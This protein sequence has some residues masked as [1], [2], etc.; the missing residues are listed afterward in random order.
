MRQFKWPQ[1]RSDSLKNSVN[2]M[3]NIEMQKAIQAILEH[4]KGFVVNFIDVDGTLC[5]SIFH[6]LKKLPHGQQN[7]S[8]LSPEFVQQLRDVEP[9]PWT[10]YNNRY[11]WIGNVNIIITGRIEAHRGVTMEWIYKH[12]T[13]GKSGE[14][15]FSFL[16]VPFN[17]KL[18]DE[19]DSYR[20]Y[21]TRKGNRLGG[22]LIDWTSTLVSSNFPTQINV[23]EDDVNVL[24][25]LCKGGFMQNFTV[26]HVN[27]WIV[28][29]GQA[30]VAFTGNEE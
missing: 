17:D 22:L 7:E 6:N 2:A 1:P 9:F 19:N 25:E 4:Y 10:K 3:D 13:Y 8:S 12:F 29:N 16:S 20:D 30:P 23:F 24:R 27:C 14:Y 18:G 5:P 11:W 21:Y 28:K 26:S 15:R